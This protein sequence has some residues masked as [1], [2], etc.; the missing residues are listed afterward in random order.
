MSSHDWRYYLNSPEIVLSREGDL[1]LQGLG[2]V[3]GYMP[4]N[5]TNA[6][7]HA[8]AHINK[9]DSIC[10]T[11]EGNF[12][13]KRNYTV[14]VSINKHE[15]FAVVRIGDK[16]VTSALLEVS[17]DNLGME[18]IDSAL[19]ELFKKVKDVVEQSEYVRNV[20]DIPVRRMDNWDNKSTD[21]GGVFK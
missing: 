6:G 20:E 1:Y 2:F 16:Y 11:K 3:R 21:D 5:N 8:Y 10:W 9:P 18:A 17:S 13:S 19:D 7:A 15:S 14:E 4:D 12:R